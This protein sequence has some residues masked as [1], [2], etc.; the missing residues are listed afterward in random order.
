MLDTSV[1]NREEN[2]DE[3]KTSRDFTSVNSGVGVPP[4]ITES[5]FKV[6]AFTIG[7]SFRSLSL[8]LS[9]WCN[10]ISMKKKKSSTRIYHWARASTREKSRY[11]TIDFAREKEAL[12]LSAMYIKHR[13]TF[14]ACNRIMNENPGEYSKEIDRSADYD[15]NGVPGYR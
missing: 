5:P 11:V 13:F 8:S 12:R 6:H 15:A 1:S 4:R 2:R 3:S 14:R 10:E 7:R 9:K